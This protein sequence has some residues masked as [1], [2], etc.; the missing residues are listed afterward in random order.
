MASYSSSIFNFAFAWF[1]RY[2]FSNVAAKVIPE[3]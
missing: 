3:T 1:A 2:I